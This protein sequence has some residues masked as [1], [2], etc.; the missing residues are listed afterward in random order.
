[1]AH[2]LLGNEADYPQKSCLPAVLSAK[3]RTL[4]SAPPLEPDIWAHTL[5]YCENEEQA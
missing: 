4:Q 2:F 5:L 1:M 3:S